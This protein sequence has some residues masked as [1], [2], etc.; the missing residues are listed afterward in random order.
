MLKLKK[1]KLILIVMLLSGCQHYSSQENIDATNQVDSLAAYIAVSAF[2]RD[3]CNQKD[4]DSDNT[5]NQKALQFAEKVRWDT[6]NPSYRNLQL[7]A[8]ERKR[9]LL[10][11]TTANEIKCTSLNS[12]LKYI[13]QG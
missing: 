7:V 6:K 10:E 1:N 3:Y 4:I 12:E 2:L 11:D 13:Q 8:S 5:L 9:K